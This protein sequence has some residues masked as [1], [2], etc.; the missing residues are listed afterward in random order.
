MRQRM[1]WWQWVVIGVG[2][3][4]SALGGANFLLT[5]AFGATFNTLS[6]KRGKTSF[7]FGD[8]RGT[9]KETAL[10]PTKEQRAWCE[11]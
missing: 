2:L 3:P 4:S 7:P 10:A 5:N 11:E 9:G 1:A 8:F 6:G